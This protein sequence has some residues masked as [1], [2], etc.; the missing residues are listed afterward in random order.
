MK[1]PAIQCLVRAGLQMAVFWFDPHMAEGRENAR[2]WVSLIRVLNSI[3]EGS[4][5]TT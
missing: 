3:H 5:L 2:S 4:T 1:I